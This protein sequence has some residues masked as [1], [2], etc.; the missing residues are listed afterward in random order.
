MKFRIILP[1]VYAILYII[2]VMVTL[3]GKG[4]LAGF[5]SICVTTP[6]SLLLPMLVAKLIGPI[7]PNP[8]VIWPVQIAMAAFNGL[9]Y[10]FTGWGIDSWLASRKR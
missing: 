8:F 4:M 6:W 3:T 5:W 1:S 9:I 10:F 2:S 7:P